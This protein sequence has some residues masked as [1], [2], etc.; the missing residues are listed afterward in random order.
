MLDRPQALDELFRMIREVGDLRLI[1][2]AEGR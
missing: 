1:I 2:L